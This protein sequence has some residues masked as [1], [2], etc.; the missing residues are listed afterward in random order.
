MERSEPA[1]V[2]A[3]AA[4]FPDPLVE[5]AVERSTRRTGGVR[6]RR[7]ALTSVGLAAG[8]AGLVGLGLLLGGERAEPAGE[9]SSLLVVA[10]GVGLAVAG[11]TSVWRRPG[12]RFG[13][14]TIVAGFAWLAVALQASS[15]PLAFTVGTLAGGLWM[16]ALVHALLSYPEGRLG[17]GARGAIAAAGWLVASVLF[18][19][20]YLL[21][22]QSTAAA[23]PACPPLLLTIAEAP[24]LAATLGAVHALAAAAVLVLAAVILVRFSQRRSRP[25]RSALGPFPLVAAATLVALALA[26]LFALEP[27]LAG[28]EWAALDWIGYPA[29]AMIGL[30]YVAAI[31]GTGF[32]RQRAVSELVDR[33]SE[34]LPPEGVHQAL[35]RALGDRSVEIAYWEP[36]RRRYVDAHGRRALLPEEG[37]DRAWTAIERAGRPVAGMTYDASLRDQPE[38][39]HRAGAAVGL[40]LEN[41]R[42]ETALA[43][44][45]AELRDSRARMVRATDAERR[46]IER[47]LH[48][49]AQQRLVALSVRLRLVTARLRSDPEA[50]Q[51]LIEE[52]SEDLQTTLSELRE[53]ARGIHPAVLSDR[54]LRSALDVLT[55][56]APVPVE[57]D[58]AGVQRLD[59]EIEAGAYFVVA[60]ALTNVAKYSAATF[61]TVTVRRDDGRLLVEVRDDGIGGADPSTGSGLRGLWDRVGAL[62]GRIEIVSPPGEGTLV[63]AEIPCGG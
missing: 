5:G 40:A 46:R 56:R 43:A 42:L 11:V 20:P 24:A 10:T 61:A 8:V 32:G 23:C 29:L 31:V 37:G 7:R 58:T 50:A 28:L 30:A 39:V 17:R 55:A 51:R 4:V 38:L 19:L 13:A 52:C 26:R 41:E 1:F 47:D 22:E 25:E 16:G 34:P 27:S 18:A 33:L 9:L 53:L 35:A 6:G 14:L 57:L 63:R 49:G 59:R 15:E 36:E 62:D 48:D 45:A 44:R 54:G 3:Q 12:S 2:R 60:E 21:S